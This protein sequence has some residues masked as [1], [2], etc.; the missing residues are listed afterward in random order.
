MVVNLTQVVTIYLFRNVP[1]KGP[2][3]QANFVAQ[4]D[5]IFVRLKLHQVSNRFETPAISRRLNRVEIGFGV[6]T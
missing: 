1:F 5:A 2:F 6:L 3:T 4:L